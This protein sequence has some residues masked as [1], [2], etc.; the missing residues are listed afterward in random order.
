M[1]N[2]A[3][4]EGSPETVQHRHF[5]PMVGRSACSVFVHN[6]DDRSKWVGPDLEIPMAL[7]DRAR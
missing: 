7:F 3:L 2:W 4:I 1:L 6:Q 5:V